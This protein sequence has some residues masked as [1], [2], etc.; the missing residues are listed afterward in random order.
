VTGREH[1]DMQRYI[2]AIIAGAVPSGFLIAT[3]ALMDFRYHMQA[4]EID[5]EGLI[6]LRSALAEFFFF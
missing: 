1:Q 4:Q 3:Q 2:T 6:K 5:D